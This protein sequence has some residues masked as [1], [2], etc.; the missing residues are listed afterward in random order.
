MKSIQVRTRGQGVRNWR[1]YCVRTL[2]MP[3]YST[4]ALKFNLCYY[5]DACI[6]VN[7]DITIVN[8]LITQVAFKTCAQFTKC[9]KKIDGATIDDATYE[10]LPIT[11]NPLIVC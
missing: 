8:V 10:L 5:N 9:I 7:D 4:E 3:S 11:W 2:W 1:F 6:L